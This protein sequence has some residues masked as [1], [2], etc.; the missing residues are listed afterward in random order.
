VIH[1]LAHRLGWNEGQIVFAHDAHHERCAVA[2]RCDGCGV[3]SGAHWSQSFTT[4]DAPPW[5]GRDLT[6]GELVG[7]VWSAGV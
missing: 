6:A 4:W 7:L 5:T 3:I 2:F 1:A